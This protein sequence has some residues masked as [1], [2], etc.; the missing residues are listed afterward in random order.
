MG[1]WQRYLDWRRRNVPSLEALHDGFRLRAGKSSRTVRWEQI[2]RVTA[3]KRDLVTT[4]LLCLLVLLTDGIIELHED[5]PGFA[6]VEDQLNRT[7]APVD[8]WKSAVLFPAFEPRALEIFAR[9]A[10]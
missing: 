3:F 6:A 1:W 7:L 9:A 10:A 8:D 2:Q 4:D 5:M